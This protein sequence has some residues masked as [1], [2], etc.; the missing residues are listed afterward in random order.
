MQVFFSSQQLE[1][2]QS[3]KTSFNKFV[4]IRIYAAQ[5]EKQVPLSG[6]T[7]STELRNIP[8]KSSL[9][10]RTILFHECCRFY[11]LKSVI[12]NI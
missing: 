3:K 2:V 8:L 4:G 12:S 11:F 9:I 7:A 1:F 10:M 6:G 5:E